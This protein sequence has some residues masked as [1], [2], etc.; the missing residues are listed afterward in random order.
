MQNIISMKLTHPLLS[1]LSFAP[2][3]A[4]HVADVSSK[5]SAHN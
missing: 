5:P 4:L 2:L 1:A 3:A